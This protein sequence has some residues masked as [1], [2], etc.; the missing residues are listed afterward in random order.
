MDVRACRLTS[1]AA[2]SSPPRSSGG[3]PR[4]RGGSGARRGT[5]RWSASGSPETT[6]S[7]TAGCSPGRSRK[8]IS[9]PALGACGSITFDGQGRVVSVC[10][11]VSGPQLY[12]FD[13]NTLA[14][15]AT[16]SLPP[17][18]SVPTN[19]FQDFTGGGYFYLD[20]Q[21]PV[22][23]ST[24]TKHILVIAETPGTPGFSL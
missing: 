6:T 11:G 1:A 8:T 19:T 17:R 23:T 12:M 20:N 10:V 16:Y 13:P 5:S 22:V 3:S 2:S 7:E 4:S 15:L 21:D 14:T 24:T 18:Q 9:A